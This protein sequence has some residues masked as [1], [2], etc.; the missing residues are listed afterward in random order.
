MLHIVAPAIE[1]LCAAFSRNGYN[2]TPIIDLGVLVANADGKVDDR[3]RETLLAVFQT[4][5]DTALPSDV[6][7]NLVT[8]SLEVI[9][10]AGPEA[11]ARLIAEILVDCDAVEEGIVVA[12]T[13]AFA[14]EGFSA[15][16]RKVIERIADEAGLPRQRLGELVKKIEKEFDGDPKS[17]REMLV[18]APK[19]V[20]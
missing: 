6:V 5:L 8:A 18:S 9:K 20:R 3:E 1:Q 16:E 12:L 10:V 2:P 17:L 14:S 7:D 15:A 11:R 13:V 19:S 4:L